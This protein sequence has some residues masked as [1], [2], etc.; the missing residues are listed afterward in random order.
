VLMTELLKLAVCVAMAAW[1]VG[2]PLQ[3]QSLLRSELWSHG[4]QQA[5]LRC[6]IPAFAFTIQN[7]LLFFALGNLEAPTYQVTYQ[8]KTLFTALCSRVILGRRLKEMQWLALFLLTAGAVLVVDAPFSSLFGGD[9][10]H[11]SSGILSAYAA[12]LGAVLAAALLS[13]FA[14]VYFERMLKTVPSSKEADAASLWIRNIQLGLFATPLA[15]CAMLTNDGAHVW[16]HGV[17][18]GFDR[19]VW[20]IVM[21]NGL[22]GLLVAATMKYA[23][24]IVKCFATGIAVVCGS[25]V[26]VPIFGFVLS[27]RFCAGT[28]STILASVLYA[29]APVTSCC[30]PNGEY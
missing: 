22:G 27:S 11:D 4:G 17:L 18:R 24:N 8:T 6:A 13:A 9:G 23:D 25:V 16:T 21:I 2:G 29:R 5:T 30:L 10:K 12:G 19:V 28:T 15:A 14:S 3:L 26:S 7:N 1:S 20:A